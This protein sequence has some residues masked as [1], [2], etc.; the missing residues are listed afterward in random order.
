M[1]LITS[2]ENVGTLTPNLIYVT[3]AVLYVCEVLF[4]KL[5]NKQQTFHKTSLMELDLV[6]VKDTI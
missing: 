6:S 5:F 2:C 3:F 1:I 4:N